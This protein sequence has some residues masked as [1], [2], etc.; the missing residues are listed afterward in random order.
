[1]TDSEKVGISQS[2]AERAALSAFEAVFANGAKITLD[3]H[4]IYYARRSW[5]YDL[6]VSY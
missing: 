1:M 6:A 2:D 5:P 4:L 3:H